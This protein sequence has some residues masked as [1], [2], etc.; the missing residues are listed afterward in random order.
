VEDLRLQAVLVAVVDEPLEDAGGDDAAAADH[1]Q[2]GPALELLVD[3]LVGLVGVDDA[4]V[5][6]VLRAVLLEVGQELHARVADADVHV[7]R[8]VGDALGARRAL[9]RGQDR[10]VAAAVA[11]AHHADLPLHRHVEVAHASRF[12]SMA[13]KT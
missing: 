11:L 6:V 7:G 10:E 8:P 9:G 2:A 13:V 3:L 1:D 4:D 5:V 12:F